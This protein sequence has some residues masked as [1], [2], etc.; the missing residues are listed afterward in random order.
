M[1]GRAVHR[2]AVAAV[3]GAGAAVGA[4]YVLDGAGRPAIG[5]WGVVWGTSAFLVVGAVS[6][7][8]GA[9]KSRT[10]RSAKAILGLTLGALS[11]WG[12]H[13]ASPCRADPAALP[14]THV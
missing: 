5:F 12:E 13:R 2:L 6:L 7:L 4:G 14:L 11:Y 1:H 3:A 9:E 8:L 10:R